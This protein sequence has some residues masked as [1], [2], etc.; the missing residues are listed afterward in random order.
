MPLPYERFERVLDQYHYL[1]T[2]VS[3]RTHAV[4]L[5]HLGFAD[6][7]TMDTQRDTT[8]VH[9]FGAGRY[10]DFNEPGLLLR[11]S[12]SDFAIWYAQEKTTQI[13]VNP[14]LSVE[15]ESEDGIVTPEFMLER[16]REGFEVIDAYN[17]HHAP[18]YALLNGNVEIGNVRYR[19]RFMANGLDE[20]TR[21]VEIPHFQEVLAALRAGSLKAR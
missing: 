19:R 11:G 21:R 10:H 14:D 20:V 4:L 6:P 18:Y 12:R 9:V 5:S 2:L 3:G 15:V 8:H 1:E 13:K 17:T 7:K 16:M